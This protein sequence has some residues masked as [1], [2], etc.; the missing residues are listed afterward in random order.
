MSSVVRW[1]SQEGWTDWINESTSGRL[2]RLV[3]SALKLPFARCPHIGTGDYSAQRVARWSWGQRQRTEYNQPSG[4]NADLK[5]DDDTL[6]P[7]VGG[8]LD[9]TVAS[10]GTDELSEYGYNSINRNA[11]L[12]VSSASDFLF[13]TIG[14]GYMSVWFKSYLTDYGDKFAIIAGGHTDV[15]APNYEAYWGIGIIDN[16]IQGFIYNGSSILGIPPLGGAVAIDTEWHHAL[17]AVSRAAPPHRSQLLIVDH[18]YGQPIDG[19]HNQSFSSNTA[20]YF[21]IG[22]SSINPSYGFAGLID[23]LSISEWTDPD[24]LRNIIEDP[25]TYLGR[26]TIYISDLIGN[27]SDAHRF[28]AVNFL[29]D[30]FDTGRDN[31]LLSGVYVNYENPNNSSVQFSFRASD[32]SFS[33][34]DIEPSWTG[35]TAPNAVLTAT[36]YTN[37]EL[38]IWV[39]GR[40]QQVRMRLSP[41]TSESSIVDPLQ[42]DTPVI[43]SLE[44]STGVS[45]KIL[46]PT[47]AAY[48][49]GTIL[50]QVVSFSGPKTIDKISLNLSVTT[51]DRNDF[52]VGTGGQIAFP[53]AIW[54]ESRHNWIFSPVAHWAP[55]NGWETSGTTIQNTEQDDDWDTEEDAI[56]N[57]PYLKYNVFFPQAG[58]YQLWGFGYVDGN[59]IFY[60]FDDDTTDLRRMNLG[61]DLSGW[62]AAPRWTRFGSLFLEEGGLH[63]FTVYLAE[64][65]T[66]ILDQWMFTQNTQIDSELSND[67]YSLPLPSSKGP[68]NTAVRLRSLYGGEVDDLLNPQASPSTTAWAWLNSLTINASEKFNYEIRDSAGMGVTFYDGLSIEYWQ[69][70]GSSKH[71]ASWDYYK[72]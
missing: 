14:P 3:G 38:N 32:T 25:D 41:S 71:F 54:S 59:G 51:T 35:F 26:S 2:P 49:P 18:E 31:S 47:R 70:G 43:N 37:D 66:T 11:G 1:D 52:V 23:E 36:N 72:V 24:D 45:E 12:I 30:V 19:V 57:A 9:H 13:P 58:V 50:G 39:R 53:A 20:S 67:N 28:E 40:Y 69:I 27:Y 63:T 61:S 10:F 34:T 29:S 62:L 5:D 33:P 46:G 22:S 48:E 55:S 44:I 56:A 42:L 68:F 15:E 8:N 4:F 64:R 60:G 17:F 65:N 6:N 16:T 21:S 7:S